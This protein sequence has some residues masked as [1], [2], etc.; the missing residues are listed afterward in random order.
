MFW[1][2]SSWGIRAELLPVTHDI[3][4]VKLVVNPPIV[5][6]IPSSFRTISNQATVQIAITLEAIWNFH[7]GHV[8]RSYKDNMLVLL[9]AMEHR[10][11]E[12]WQEHLL[13]ESS[14]SSAGSFK[15]VLWS[16]RPSGCIKL[17]LD[18]ALLPSAAMIAVIARNEEGLMIKAW[19]KPYNTCEP[20]IAE[21]AAIHWAIQLAKAENWRDIIIESDSKTCVDALVLD[22][23]A[24]K[25]NILVL[26]NNVKLLA[27]EFSICDFCWV[28]LE[29]NMA[30]HTL[31]KLVPPPNISV[32][33][34]PKNLSA[35][36]E[37]AWFRDFSC[38]PIL[39]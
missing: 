26:C 13:G 5:V 7:N 16:P 12:H 30:A 8:H 23:A 22:Q 18:A 9:K 21:A 3:D 35:P 14:V 39:V 2:G 25:W 6:A 38:I 28:R 17:N 1:F 11:V 10:V 36:L 15:D 32:V 19:A 37:E 29:A 27:S 20:L 31:A 33:Y 4:V 34:F 24:C